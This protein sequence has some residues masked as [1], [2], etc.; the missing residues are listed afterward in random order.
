VLHSLGI[1]TVFDELNRRAWKLVVAFR[2]NFAG[3]GGRF[4]D[5]GGE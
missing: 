2:S 1:Q 3:W 5:F 4:G